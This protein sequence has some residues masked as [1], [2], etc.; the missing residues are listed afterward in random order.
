MRGR[1]TTAVIYVCFTKEP[2]GS[3]NNNISRRE[4]PF[5]L[6]Y[7]PLYFLCASICDP[8]S[9]VQVYLDKFIKKSPR[10]DDLNTGL[11]TKHLTT[12]I[13]CATVVDNGSARM[14]F[15]YVII[16][17]IPFGW[18]KNWS[19]HLTNYRMTI[20]HSVISVSVWNCPWVHFGSR[21]FA[22]S[23]SFS[24]ALFW[25]FVIQTRQLNYNMTDYQTW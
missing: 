7:Y 15:V 16:Q 12:W 14:I 23:T 10:L 4:A 3:I 11:P 18:S 5:W 2:R 1:R 24:L 17:Y 20:G 6:A 8:V 13:E 21:D 22:I 19:Q 25:I 9:L